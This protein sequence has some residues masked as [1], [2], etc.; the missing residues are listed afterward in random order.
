MGFVCIIIPLYRS[1]SPAV[2]PQVKN[3]LSRHLSLN[4]LEK[5]QL[6]KPYEMEEPFSTRLLGA[7][8]VKAFN[9]LLTQ[10]RPVTCLILLLFLCCYWLKHF[11]TCQI[12]LIVFDCNLFFSRPKDRAI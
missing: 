1:I 9:A 8:T 3:S 6:P 5:R 2:Q 11:I 12:A 7:T 10:L 4:Q